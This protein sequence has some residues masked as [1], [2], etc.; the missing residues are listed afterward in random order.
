MSS[1]LFGLS[2][3]GIKRATKTDEPKRSEVSLERDVFLLLALPE[4][5][6]AMCR[7]NKKCLMGLMRDI[8]GK[9]EPPLMVLWI[10]GHCLRL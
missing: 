6:Q 10:I 1:N 4:H 9:V 8:I 5:M 3:A 7:V 2:V